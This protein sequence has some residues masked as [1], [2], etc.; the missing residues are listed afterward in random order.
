M[1]FRA[2]VPAPTTMSPKARLIGVVVVYVPVTRRWAPP[3]RCFRNI[4]NR[5]PPPPSTRSP[6]AGGAI[7]NAQ[8]CLTCS[9]ASSAGSGRSGLIRRF[10]S[11][12]TGSSG[13]SW[14]PLHT[15]APSAVRPLL[16]RDPRPPSQPGLATRS[17]LRHRWRVRP[18]SGRPWPRTLKDS[19]CTADHLPP[20][21]PSPPAPSPRTLVQSDQ[22]AA[23]RGLG[24]SD[25]L[26][27]ANRR[28]GRR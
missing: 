13:T 18:A 25:D 9:T 26:L 12:R 27:Q 20:P 3:G 14:P 28:P 5:P 10:P 23:S 16:R 19:G 8:R 1:L 2:E 22:L 11:F 4:W 15:G 6:G 7:M 24:T 21:P 17:A